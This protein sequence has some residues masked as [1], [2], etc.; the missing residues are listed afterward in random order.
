MIDYVTVAQKAR[1][2][3]IEELLDMEH[4][5]AKHLLARMVAEGILETTGGMGNLCYRLKR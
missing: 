5:R 4:A 3:E 2:A 1:T